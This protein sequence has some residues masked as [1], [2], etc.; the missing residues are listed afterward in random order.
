VHASRRRSNSSGSI[1][2]MR[3]LPTLGKVT[4][5]NG[6]RSMISQRTSQWKKAR[7]ERA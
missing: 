1:G 5:S 2:R 7:A 4:R 3:G 6:L